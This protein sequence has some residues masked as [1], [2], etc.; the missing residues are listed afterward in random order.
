MRGEEAREEA[1]K[2]AEGKVRSDEE[3]GDMIGIRG[4]RERE[5]KRRRGDCLA[6]EEEGRDGW[7][8][9]R[10]GLCV[11]RRRGRGKRSEVKRALSR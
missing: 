10:G 5:R 9:G 4:G 2:G 8:N 7:K 11:D 3:G 1:G 6:R